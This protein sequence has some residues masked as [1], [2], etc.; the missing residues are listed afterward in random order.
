[1][2]SRNIYVI[3]MLHNLYYVSPIIH[4]FLL[5]LPAS[6]K[7][8]VQSY[9]RSNLGETSSRRVRH[10]SLRKLRP[11]YNSKRK[12]KRG[13]KEKRKRNVGPRNCYRRCLHMSRSHGS[14]VREYVLL[15]NLVTSGFRDDLN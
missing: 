13:K 14:I 1:M 12:K 7:R 11:V 9:N 3:Y 8:I 15:Q 5:L 2:N 10:A 6:Q 4:L